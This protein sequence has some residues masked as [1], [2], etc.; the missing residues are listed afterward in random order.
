M[1]EHLAYASEGEDGRT[2][3]SRPWPPGWSVDHVAETG[4]TNGDLLDSA[5]GRP[6]RSV[7]VADH[8]TAGRGRL[9]RRWEAPPASNLLVSMLFHA[10]PPDPGELVRRVSLAA[11]DAARSLG[12][13]GELRLKW[14]NDVLLDG[15]K[16]AG[17]LAQRGTTGAVVVGIGINVGW[18]PDGAARLGA[19]VARTE[20]LAAL[21]EAFD[22]LPADPD[23][24]R[25]R[26][27]DELSTIGQRVRA[28][29]PSG[30]VIGTAIDVT[31]VGQLVIRGDD[32][33]VH[34]IDV[35]DVTHLRPA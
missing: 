27:R 34:E 9:D 5:T 13:A 1:A 32:A 8:Q 33:L 28:E 25:G 23:A 12:V 31:V 30:D 24:L 26:Y 35:A 19:D 16:L 3:W 18:S 7:L 15:A 14:P 6:D 11:V 2:P 10:V 17:V 22:A 20:L 21:L 29:M 4:S